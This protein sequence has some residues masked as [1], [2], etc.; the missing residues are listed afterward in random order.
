M[1]NF[2]THSY[3]SVRDGV[4]SPKAIAE[5]QKESGKGWFCITDH[6]TM[7]GHPEAFEVAHKLG[8]NFFA[9]CEFYVKPDE[10]FD[11]KEN[12]LKLAE[13]QKI[14]RK[15]TATE[16][17]KNLAKAEFDKIT[18]VQGYNEAYYH[19][20]VFA[21]NK[22]GLLNLYKINNNGDFY[23]KT[24]V[25]K[26][27]LLKY[28][29]GLIVLSG[30]PGGELFKMIEYGYIEY[31]NKW[32][33]DFKEAYGDRLYFELMFHD[34]VVNVEDIEGESDLDRQKRRIEREKELYS[35]GIELARAHGI[36]IIGSNDSHYTNPEDRKNWLFTRM[37]MIGVDKDFTGDYH[38]MG[39]N[40]IFE[41]AYPGLVTAKELDENEEEI[42]ARYEK[43]DMS[44]SPYES[45]LEDKKKLERLIW[46]GF[47]KIRKGTP[48]E[49][50]SLLQIPYELSVIQLKDFDRYF[51][52]TRHV[53]KSAFEKG[54]LVGP[55]RGS[56]AGSE[57]VYLLGITNT[58]PIKYGLMFER[59]LNPGRE[60]MPDIDLDLASVSCKNF[61]PNQAYKD[62]FFTDNEELVTDEE[63]AEYWSRYKKLKEEHDDHRRESVFK[64]SGVEYFDGFCGDYPDLC[65]KSN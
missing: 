55:G 1:S 9:G 20:T 4:Q 38:M 56:G 6:G 37:A 23:Y 12:T 45:T 21:Y 26:E 49:E 30:C 11:G 65:K 51:I 44:R 25:R 58:D 60:A 24:R 34:G 14:L 53:V 10:M 36:K 3:Y 22:T 16:E 33:T 47:K 18:S 41:R 28:N 59:F 8:M 52:N 43:Y 35:K 7:A 50:T 15:K 27:D 13:L 5:F 46:T 48:E 29:E 64:A 54:I 31:A 42:I 63:I 61:A 57:C 62:M 39:D 2:H 40:E 19:L 17:E 32:L